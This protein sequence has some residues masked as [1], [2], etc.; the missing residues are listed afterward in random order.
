LAATGSLPEEK[1]M[2]GQVPGETT[3]VT[4]LGRLHQQPGDAAAWHEFVARYRPRILAQCLAL[5]LQVT[6]AEDVTQAVLLR[7]VEKLPQFHYDPTQCFRAWLKTVTHHLLVDYL[8]EQR[9]QQGSGE[10]AII[11]LLE[12]VQARENLVR[13]MEAEYERELFEQ[14][15]RR[16]REQVPAQQWEA[17][18][19]TALDQ[20]SGAEAAARL[21]M[22]VATV[23]TARSKVQ[24]LVRE[25]VHRLEGQSGH[26]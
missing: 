19:L 1:T 11:H 24:K 10:T 16:V 18:R 8:A 7:L 4:L 22:L 12:N 20:L 3:S 15:L 2:P 14:A 9:R 21:G 6:D 26:G 23:Y 13:E 25:E 5:G 17:F